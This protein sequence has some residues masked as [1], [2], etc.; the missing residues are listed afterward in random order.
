[1]E[2]LD[3]RDCKK[4]NPCTDLDDNNPSLKSQKSWGG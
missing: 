2:N 4:L 3:F 1:M